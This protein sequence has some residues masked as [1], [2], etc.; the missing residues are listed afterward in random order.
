MQKMEQGYIKVPK[1]LLSEA[2]HDISPAARLLYIRLLDLSTLSE[3]NGLTDENGRYVYC[4]VQQA[5][6]ILGCG[7]DKVGRVY[8]ELEK[9]ALIRRKK[10]GLGKADR[11]Y[12]LDTC[13]QLRKED[14]QTSEN[15]T[16][17]KP[18][19]G[20]QEIGYSEPINSEIS[21][22][23][24]N[25]PQ[26]IN[27]DRWEDR[28]KAQIDYPLLVARHDPE[29]LQGFVDVMADVM[30]TDEPTLRVNQCA[31]AA[32]S[33]KTR[34]SQLNSMH[35][36]YVLECLSKNT[37]KISNAKAYLIT[38]LYNAPTTIST[39][40]QAQVNHDASQGYR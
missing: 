31:M 38:A 1:A 25:N 16:S 10:Q 40:Y 17:G 6:E 28:I 2:Y 39:Y 35:I 37:R 18:E 20:A 32:S 9:A 5:Q 24:I 19:I 15:Q 8:R 36:E 27:P 11:I 29:Q 13:F 12:P 23:E 7:H 30:R 34:F 4:S 33:V 22:T 3:K 21:D 14:P 26:S